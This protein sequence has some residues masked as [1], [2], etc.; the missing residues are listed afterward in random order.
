MKDEVR[1]ISLHFILHRSYF[2]IPVLPFPAPRL[3]KF[4]FRIKPTSLIQT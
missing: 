3:Y 1:A 2:I 4:T